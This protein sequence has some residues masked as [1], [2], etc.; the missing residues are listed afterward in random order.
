M[1]VVSV[2]V[3]AAGLTW[4]GRFAWDHWVHV[5]ILTHPAVIDLGECQRGEIAI[6]RF[7]ISNSGN[8]ELK[9][10]QF[11]TSCSCAGVQQE[12]DGSFR[13]VESLV[14]PPKGRAE[15]VVRTAVG[16]TAATRQIIQVWFSSNDPV[17]PKG[18]ME[19]VIP[20]VRGGVYVLPT[21]I[22]F[23]QV[24]VGSARHQIVE[25]YDNRQTGRTIERVVSSQPDIIGVRLLPPLPPD[26][27]DPFVT[28]ERGGRLIA[29]IEITPRTSKAGPLNARV[30]IQLA[31]EEHPDVVLTS[32]EVIYDVECR[33]S[34][35]VI[36]RRV[37]GKPEFSGRIHLR[38]RDGEPMTVEV[39]TAPPGMFAKVQP[40]ANGSDELVVEIERAVSGVVP[41]GES[42]IRL[43]VR[44]GMRESS[45]TV[46]VFIAAA[47]S[48]RATGE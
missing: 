17:R 4:A 38:H 35:V 3:M 11:F 14:I 10:N 9:L 41:L 40:P 29:R 18:Y 27:K 24:R 47:A 43:R 32:G 6:G 25:V 26:H 42:N 2:L 45:I 46:P 21:A 37:A 12:V 15:L 48:T 1:G 20:H 44:T 30:E 39:E 36:P 13:R 31:G 7:T 28:H 22:S 5:P 23:G 19:V 16:A 33:P 34:T 8:R